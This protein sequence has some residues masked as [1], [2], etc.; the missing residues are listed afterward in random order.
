MTLYQSDDYQDIRDA[1]RALCAEFPDEYH[2]KI[3]ADR[4]YPEDFVE[5]LSGLSAAIRERAVSSKAFR[6]SKPQSPLASSLLISSCL[7]LVLLHEAQPKP[8]TVRPG[9]FRRRSRCAF[10]RRSAAATPRPLR[11]SGRPPL[12]APSPPAPR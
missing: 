12:T 1:V 7:L 10:V 11:P 4:A 6:Q 3:D 5:A 2:R 8:Q 9:I